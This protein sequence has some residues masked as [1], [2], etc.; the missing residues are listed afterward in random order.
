MNHYSLEIAAREHHNDLL[1]AAEQH[2]LVMAVQANGSARRPPIRARLG[3]MFI[4]VGQR[5]KMLVFASVFEI[6]RKDA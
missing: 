6:N 1:R 5:L 3:A 2:R 4:A